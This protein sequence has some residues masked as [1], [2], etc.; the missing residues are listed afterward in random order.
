M[1][2]SIYKRL[3]KYLRLY[4]IMIIK[5]F[6][7]RL[8]QYDDDYVENIILYKKFEAL[9]TPLSMSLLL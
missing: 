3:K 5:N 6:I 9:E 8:I 7:I 4:L 2:N 1:I